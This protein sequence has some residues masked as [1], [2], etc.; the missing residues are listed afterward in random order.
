MYVGSVCCYGLLYQGWRA[1]FSVV[2]VVV[3]VVVVA[4]CCC[5]RLCTV[6]SGRVFCRVAV[7]FFVND[8]S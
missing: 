6:R 4:A 3:V 2:V 5:F 7:L 8:M 1:C